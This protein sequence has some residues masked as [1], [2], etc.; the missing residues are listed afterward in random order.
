MRNWCE[1][2]RF[3]KAV[4]QYIL[5]CVSLPLHSPFK[6][7]YQTFKTCTHK[8]AEHTQSIRWQ[9]PTNFLGVLDLFVGSRL[10]SKLTKHN[11]CRHSSINGS[12]SSLSLTLKLPTCS[13]IRVNSRTYC[14]SPIFTSHGWL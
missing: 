10:N 9:W 7:K 12:C 13:R 1:K 4:K 5:P 2:N 14:S 6:T 11:D 3:D 8:M